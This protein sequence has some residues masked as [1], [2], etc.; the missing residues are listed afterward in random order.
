MDVG[1]SC[2]AVLASVEH[3]LV[4]WLPGSVAIKR[5]IEPSALV[6]ADCIF[7]VDTTQETPTRVAIKQSV[8]MTPK[9]VAH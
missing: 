6:S 3:V 7:A 5:P 1:A 4:V 2:F 8:N 9:S